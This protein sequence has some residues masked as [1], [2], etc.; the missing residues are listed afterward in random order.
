MSLH[1]YGQL[2]DREIEEATRKRRSLVILT[3]LVDIVFIL[4]I[5]FMLAS[6]ISDYRVIGFLTPEG[7]KQAAAFEEPSA[8]LVRV[9]VDGSLDVSG[10]PM[11][12]VRIA[13]EVA[14]RSLSE[15]SLNY[16]VQPNH[17]VSVQQ[18]IAVVDLLKS[19]GARN[20]SLTGRPG[21]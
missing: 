5:F 3:P 11:S 17:G 15:N 12:T 14:R 4:L 2:K 13:E 8:V 1:S 7:A 19:S 9:D 6:S 20:V 21:S 16:L 18:V 10:E